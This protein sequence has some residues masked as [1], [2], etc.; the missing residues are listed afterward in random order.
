MP[1]AGPLLPPT[2]TTIHL[3]SYT[4]NKSPHHENT[5]SLTRPHRVLAVRPLLGRGCELCA[6]GALRAPQSFGCFAALSLFCAVLFALLRLG[7]WPLEILIGGNTFGCSHHLHFYSKLQSWLHKAPNIETLHHSP[8]L[9]RHRI[10]TAHAILSLWFVALGSP[11][12]ALLLY[13]RCSR[14]L[15]CVM[16]R[17]STLVL[18]LCL[19]LNV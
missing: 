9:L 7:V 17:S 15:V 10:Y 5:F 16:F 18:D 8:C 3:H 6:L 11:F 19:S 2:L 14:L 12:P 13:Y 1:L 4:H